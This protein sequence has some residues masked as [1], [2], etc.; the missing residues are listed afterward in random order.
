M[1]LE[2]PEASAPPVRS[3]RD[4]A[5][6][7]FHYRNRILRLVET[8]AA[9]GLDS[10]LQTAA[11]RGLMESG[12]LVITWNLDAAEI[13]DLAAEN[14]DLAFDAASRVVE[15]ERIDFPSF[16]YEW[17]LEMLHHAAA[18]TLDL[19]EAALEAG[20]WLKDAT[21]YNILYRGARPVFID[22][23]SFEKRD[24][25]DP[26]WSAYAQ[27]VRTFILPL[28][29]GKHL[30]RSPQDVLWSRR[31]GPEPQE[32]HKWCSPW[33]RLRPGFFGTV[34]LPAWLHACRFH[35]HSTAYAAR[36]AAS[37]EQAEYIARGILGG[38]RRSLRRAAPLAAS[39]S[40]T[41]YADHK[42][43]YT[44]D[45]FAQKERF[46]RQALDHCQPAAV[47][48]IGCNEGHFSLLAA[49]SGARVVAIDSDQA[50]VG[51]LWR[52][53]R[54]QN[55]DVLPLVTDLTR[56]SPGNGWR[57]RE[58]PAFLD[59]AAGSFDLVLM[60]AVIHHM[61]I[62]ERVPL[63]E[64]LN[65]AAELTR[66]FVVIE[67]IERDDPMFRRLVRGRDLLYRD[68]TVEQ[69]E[70]EVVRDFEIL[71]TSRIE[72]LHRCLYLLRKRTLAAG[73]NR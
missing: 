34:T 33:Q 58:C 49:A 22:V 17:P 3:F 44:A 55:A 69:F 71:R 31:D 48:D 2:A 70:N 35:E 24:P 14:P 28:L 47:L 38:L 26:T 51:S 56:P 13:S 36:S 19:A 27:F 52:K 53:A 30:A 50:V 54:A 67:F 9:A 21:P 43:L 62:T 1:V 42:S 23:L 18:L 4:P 10:F 16:P 59:R 60:L 64:I 11:A 29:A 8:D 61:L 32:V 65:L 63:R 57:N 7:L 40:W 46:V 25:L 37:P 72:G 45:Q 66:S 39:S 15:H 20:Y 68:L 6:T 5:G 41:G 12:K 73:A